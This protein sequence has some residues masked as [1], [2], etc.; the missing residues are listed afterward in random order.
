MKKIIKIFILLIFVSCNKELKIIK[1]EV[2]SKIQTLPDGEWINSND[3]LSGLFTMKDNLA[4]YKNQ[5]FSTENICK[6]KIVDSIYTINNKIQK[7]ENYL[8]LTDNQDTT[9][10]KVNLSKNTIRIL[11]KDKKGNYFLKK[12]K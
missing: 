5:I 2:P 3:S 4:F 12:K 10:Y 1:T 6:Y 7:E 11:S 9:Y 8:K